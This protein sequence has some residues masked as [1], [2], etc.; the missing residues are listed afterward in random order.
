MD[1][2]P[3]GINENNW[4]LLMTCSILTGLGFLHC[5]DSATQETRKKGVLL[6]LFQIWE[7]MTLFYM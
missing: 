7:V 5:E 1:V 3:V 4:N 6:L 2:V